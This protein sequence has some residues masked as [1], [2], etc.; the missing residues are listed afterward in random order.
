MHWEVKTNT[1]NTTLKLKGT[2]EVIQIIH[3]SLYIEKF[4]WR[5]AKDLTRATK[6]ILSEQGKETEWRHQRGDADGSWLHFLSK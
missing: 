3:L 6:V 4:K 2:L 5:N 1:N